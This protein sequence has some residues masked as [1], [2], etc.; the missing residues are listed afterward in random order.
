MSN[1]YWSKVASTRLHRRR[2][3]GAASVG[4][5]SLATLGL[6][7]CG[8][9]GSGNDTDGK[10]AS[11]LTPRVDTTKQ[12]KAGGVL[13]TVQTGELS[14]LDSLTAPQPGAT[15]VSAGF[16][17]GRLLKFKPGIVTA[18]TGESEGDLAESWELSADKLQ[19]TLKLRQGVKLDSRPPTSGREVDSGDVIF[20][21][22]KMKALSDYRTDLFH[23][24]SALAPVD[25]I[26]APD[27]RTIVMKLSSPDS[28]IISLL[29]TGRLLVVQPVEADKGFDARLEARGWGPWRIKTLQPSLKVEYEKNPDYYVKGRPF[30]DGISSPFLGEYAATLAQFRAKN[31]WSGA[32]LKPE[33]ILTLKTEFPELVLQQNEFLRSAIRGKFGVKDPAS[34]FKDERVRDAFSMLIDRDLLLDA[35]L[36]VD[37][38]RKAGIPVET[39]W[40]TSLTTGWDGTWLDPKGKEFGP[41][42]MYYHHNPAEAKKLLT[43]AGFPN[44]LTFDFTYAPDNYGAVYQRYASTLSGELRNGGQNV[45]LNPQPYTAS[46]FPTV[47][48]GK[49][50]FVGFG[51]QG[52]TSQGSP[53]EM[54]RSYYHS[55]GAFAID[56][57]AFSAEADVDD[58]LTAMK[59]EFDNKKLTEMMKDFQRFMAKRMRMVL[60]PGDAGS[61]AVSWPW[62]GN[63]GIYRRYDSYAGLGAEETPY[64][65]YDASKKTL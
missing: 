47:G 45:T 17:Y 58:M 21:A 51:I 44:G 6:I 56:A 4:G 2:L 3:I 28:L 43:A 18:P 60:D 22:E 14:K 9:D 65:W 52:G 30:L 63:Q 35:L 36:S 54:L 20:S 42:A 33:D 27:K 5:L 55:Q 29:S 19:L 39:R 50:N 1:D 26:T 8:S 7:A 34:P 23:D 49:G 13:Q 32:T 40:N 41:N 48:K 15:G 57:P 10:G 37:V 46:F 53:Q 61:L 12:A 31:I 62:V 59:L 11:L 16:L 25:T 38:I 64:L 24:L